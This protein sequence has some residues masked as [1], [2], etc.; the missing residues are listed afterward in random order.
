LLLSYLDWGAGIG[1]A[2]RLLSN[3]FNRFSFY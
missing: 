1:L 2:N 3:H